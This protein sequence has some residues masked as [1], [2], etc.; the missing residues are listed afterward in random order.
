MRDQNN[1]LSWI[2]FDLCEEIIAFALE[3]FIAHGKH[4]VKHQNVAPMP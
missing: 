1:S 2:F 4:F 3:R